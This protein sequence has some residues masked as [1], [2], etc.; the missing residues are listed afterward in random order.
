[1]TTNDNR[2]F[3]PLPPLGASEGLEINAVDPR[4]DQNHRAGQLPCPINPAPPVGWKYWPRN[5]R[6]N[7]EAA[8]W[9]IAIL[10]DPKTYP[11]GSFVQKRI[12][13][14]IISARVEWHSLQGRT[15]K[16]GCFRGVNLLVSE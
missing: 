5:L 8:R 4:V 11:M 2:W 10:N 16:T 14:Q 9:T 7:P 12:G 13:G 1:M 3:P 6:V 15:G